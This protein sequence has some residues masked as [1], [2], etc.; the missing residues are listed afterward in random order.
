MN[1]W[2]HRNDADESGIN[3]WDRS[4]SDERNNADCQQHGKNSPAL[5]ANRNEGSAQARVNWGV[6]LKCK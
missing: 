4:D 3:Q 6:S 1:Q 5:S 2:K